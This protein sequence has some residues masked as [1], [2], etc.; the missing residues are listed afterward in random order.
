MRKVA[1]CCAM[2]AAFR[3]DSLRIRPPIVTKDAEPFGWPS[4]LV[5]L[6]LA[7]DTD[8]A[9]G[10]VGVAALP[11]MLLL[12]LLLLLLSSMGGAADGKA[13]HDVTD[14]VGT[15]GGELSPEADGRGGHRWATLPR[16][17]VTL[18]LLTAACWSSS[19]DLG[20][21]LVLLAPLKLLLLILLGR[22]A[23][24]LAGA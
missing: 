9:A 23:T 13:L 10:T 4:L 1:S 11:P 19:S 15:T 20:T 17:V 8:D 18:A 7:L 12:L 22:V 16:L 6:L 14:F 24:A 5:L 3:R 21:L 2:A